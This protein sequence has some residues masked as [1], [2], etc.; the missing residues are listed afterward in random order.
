MTRRARG[1]HTYLR[2]RLQG[3]PPPTDA[4]RPTRRRLA[5]S[6]GAGRYLRTTPNSGTRG[7]RVTKE[8]Y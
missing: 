7:F 4:P 5:Q 3:F 8:M 1:G 6:V 2:D